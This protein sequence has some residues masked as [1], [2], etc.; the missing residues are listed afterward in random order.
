M[1]LGWLADTFSAQFADKHWAFCEYYC[2]WILEAI[3]NSEDA[4]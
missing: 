4:L 2:A 3:E 1:V